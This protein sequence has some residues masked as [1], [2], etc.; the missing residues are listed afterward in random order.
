MG[1]RRGARMV[2]NRGKT[3]EQTAMARTSLVFLLWRT[4]AWRAVDSGK[5]G[6]RSAMRR[7]CIFASPVPAD[8][9]ETFADG[10]RSRRAAF[11]HIF[12]NTNPH[13]RR[14]R[15]AVPVAVLRSFARARG[16]SLV[17][18]AYGHP[19]VS[20]P[21]AAP[22][23][24][25]SASEARARILRDAGIFFVRDPAAVDEASVK[26]AQ[27]A[28]GAAP[29]QAALSLAEAKALEVAGRHP[30]SLVLGA[31]QLLVCG[32]RW[33]DNPETRAGARATLEALRGQTHRLISGM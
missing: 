2:D 29:E 16:R 7:L 11:I 1:R 25:A 10:G 32:S 33:F 5:A 8:G 26:A 21:T 30:G 13:A 19:G 14:P 4:M 3:K 18:H 15:D 31:D 28:R 12:F 27:R 24:L 22:L 20:M 9:S 6:T 17:G 23:V